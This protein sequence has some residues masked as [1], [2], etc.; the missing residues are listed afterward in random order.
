MKK[1]FILVLLLIFFGCG[2]IEIS[3]S[4][5]EKNDPSGLSI[6][7]EIESS[8]NSGYSYQNYIT[9]IGSNETFYVSIYAKNV[10]NIIGYDS[11]FTF[12]DERLDFISAYD[13]TEQES[14]ILGISGYL[15]IKQISSGKTNEITIAA[16]KM[17]TTGVTHSEWK[18]LGIVKFKTKSSFSTNDA[19]YFVFN[20]AQFINGSEEKIYVQLGNEQNGA[21]NATGTKP[22]GSLSFSER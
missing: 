17:D 22:S 16:A 15:A 6:A 12:N 9:G 11:R 3:D 7:M 13:K 5:N 4:D 19:A 10:E 21:I 1:Y 2:K 14:N 8:Y 20:Y 18:L